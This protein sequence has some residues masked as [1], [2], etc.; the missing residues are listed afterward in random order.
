[1]ERIDEFWTGIWEDNTKTP[2]Q[3][4]MNTIVK[5]LGQKVST[6]G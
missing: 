5:K 3:K 1:M 6:S 4:W 2:Q